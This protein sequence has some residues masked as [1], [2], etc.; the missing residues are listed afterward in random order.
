MKENTKK[1][2]ES[3]ILEDFL[4]GI[5]LWYAEEGASFLKKYDL[6]APFIGTVEHG[7]WEFE[8]N[9]GN[10]NGPTGLAARLVVEDYH[11]ILSGSCWLV[12]T[13][14]KR[15][16]YWKHKASVMRDVIYEI[17]PIYPWTE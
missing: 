3:P 12:T 13:L 2:L 15:K 9:L 11:I 8:L 7:P 5:N 14:A 1:L 6:G 10:I 17:N 4:V 16:E